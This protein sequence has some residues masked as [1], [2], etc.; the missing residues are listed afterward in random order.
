MSFG[1]TVRPKVW[2]RLMGWTCPAGRDADDG[3]AKEE[4]LRQTRK[5][6][7]RYREKTHESDNKKGK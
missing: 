2:F 7:Y 4:V 5:E 1:D 3:S 6:A